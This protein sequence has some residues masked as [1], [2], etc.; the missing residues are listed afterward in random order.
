MF[1]HYSIVALAFL[2]SACTTAPQKGD[3][4]LE[5]QGESVN[6]HFSLAA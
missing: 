4:V 6:A 1:K 3:T 5:T 2:L